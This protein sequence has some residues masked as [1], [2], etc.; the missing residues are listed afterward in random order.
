MAATNSGVIGKDGKIPWHYPDELKHFQAVTYGQVVIMGRRTFEEMSSLSLFDNRHGIV[1]TYDSEFDS[2][3]MHKNVEF[4]HSFEEFLAIKLPQNL[5]IYMIGGAMIAELFLRNNM[6][7][8][9]LLT[10]IHKEYDGDTYFSLDLL[11]NW[12]CQKVSES[13][14]YTIF[15]YNKNK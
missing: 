2:A 10:K 14:D 1:F 8:E 9:F 15:K 13:E 11:K 6:I 5:E 12:S 3:D 4:V 7:Q